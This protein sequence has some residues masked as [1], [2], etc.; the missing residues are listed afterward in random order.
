METTN[1]Y[2]T[3]PY[4][5]SKPTTISSFPMYLF[6]DAG[7]NSCTSGSALVLCPWLSGSVSTP[8]Y[9]LVIENPSSTTSTF[10]TLGRFQISVNTN[11][12][13]TPPYIV[14]Y[15]YDAS[16]APEEYLEDESQLLRTA[17]SRV[18]FVNYLAMPAFTFLYFCIFFRR[19]LSDP[20][21][22]W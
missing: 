18:L 4:F 11:V 3:A 10:S 17:N 5:D 20:E 1:Y 13:A 22:G 8:F 6:C 21:E 19:A 9:V 16:R 12:A 2:C 15:G 7:G 14:A